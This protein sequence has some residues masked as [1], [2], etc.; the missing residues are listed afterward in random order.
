M[1]SHMGGQ[2]VDAVQV[3]STDQ[4]ADYLIPS[5]DILW[6]LHGSRHQQGRVG[7]WVSTSP[8]YSTAPCSVQG[9]TL[10]VNQF[11]L[12]AGWGVRRRGP[13]LSGRRRGPGY[14]HPFRQKRIG[15]GYHPGAVN[16]RAWGAGTKPYYENALRLR[17]A[18]NPVASGLGAIRPQYLNLC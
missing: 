17:R 5:T 1:V 8:M 15:E 2:E 4:A 16:R 11:F 6:S 13:R 14:P 7:G 18:G 3:G 9:T 12:P 10:R